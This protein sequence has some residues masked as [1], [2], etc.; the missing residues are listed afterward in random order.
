MHYQR[1]H[2]LKPNVFLGNGDCLLQQQPCLLEFI[3]SV[4][5]CK[6]TD[7]AILSYTL[8]LTGLLAATEQDFSLLEVTLF[9]SIAKQGT[10]V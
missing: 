4:C 3:S 2:P 7:H 6:D 9:Y 5:K 8:K 10:D 1:Y